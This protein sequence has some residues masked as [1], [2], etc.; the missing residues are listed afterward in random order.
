MRDL[1]EIDSGYHPHPACCRSV[2]VSFSGAGGRVRVLGPPLEMIC[3]SYMITPN[4]SALT[5]RN[6]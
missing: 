5:S 4:V 3:I 6:P 2:F 1:R